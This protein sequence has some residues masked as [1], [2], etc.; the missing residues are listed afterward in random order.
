MSRPAET[1]DYDEVCGYR[2]VRVLPAERGVLAQ[3]PN[4]GRRVVLK[5]L[6]PDCLLRGQ[7][8]PSIK[9]RLERVR[10][11]AH[12]QVANLYGV[13]REEGTA[14]LIWEYLDGRT[15]EEHA[16]STR[17]SPR[18]LLVA[19]REVVLAV[20]SLHAQ[21][22]VHGALHARNIIVDDNG[23]FRLTHVSPLLFSD[24]SQDARAVVAMLK[25]M[26]ERRNEG[27]SAL[28][29]LLSEAESTS[30][31]LRQLRPRLGALLESRDLGPTGSDAPASSRAKSD[32]DHP[33]TRRRAVYAAAATAG[34]GAV[35]AGGVWLFARQGPLRPYTPP[36]APPAALHA[37]TEP[38]VE[39]RAGP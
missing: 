12:L 14:Y 6:E 25:E 36:E 15:F 16:V 31:S 1:L 26:C 22:I 20:E 23:R 10:E 33:H 30:M 32:D 27:D 18:D 34:I 7:L 17:R 39:V 9:E 35:I 29:E 4:G 28:F 19:A 21:G 11:L 38:T 5:V 24:P 37:T 13:E 2:I 8:H 3:A